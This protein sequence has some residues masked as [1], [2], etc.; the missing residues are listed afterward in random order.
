MRTPALAC[1]K[2]VPGPALIGA[3]PASRFGLPV[4]RR[5]AVIGSVPTAS[6]FAEF[7]VESSERRRSGARSFGLVDAGSLL[8][9]VLDGRKSLVRPTPVQ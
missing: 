5:P 4:I 1:A 6:N 9:T 3:P 8:G 7:Y 2:P